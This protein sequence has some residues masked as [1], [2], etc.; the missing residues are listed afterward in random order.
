MKM[1][2]GWILL[3]I[4]SSGISATTVSWV[5]WTSSSNATSVSG[6]VLV[7]S[8]LVGVQFSSTSNYNF[9]QTS[10]GT[11][12]WTGNA[13]T[14]GTISNAP[15]SDD[16]ISLNAGGTITITFSQAVVNPVFAFASWN[17]NTVSFS[18]PIVMDSTGSGYW[19]SGTLTPNTYGFVAAGTEVHGL[20]R[21]VGSFTSFSFTHTSENWHGMTIGVESLPVPEP[22]SLALLGMACLVAGFWMKKR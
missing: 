12:Y 19:G 22:T 20:I 9:V 15:A 17:S 10:G 5:D 14:N 21:L 4:L 18:T 7:G 2:L 16:I 13:Y 6:Q 3:V 11:Y 8:T 1:I